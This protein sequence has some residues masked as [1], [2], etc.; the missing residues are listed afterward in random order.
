MKLIDFLPN[1][2]INYFSAIFQVAEAKIAQNN[3]EIKK[4]NCVHSNFYQTSKLNPC[5]YYKPVII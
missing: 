1:D 3:F 5:Y 2:K 4:Q